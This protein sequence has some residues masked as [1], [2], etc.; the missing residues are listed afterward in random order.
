MREG[1]G[2]FD[3]GGEVT[4]AEDGTFSLT[5]VPREGTLLMLSGAGITPT[6]HRVPAE[7][8]DAD[9]RIVVERSCPFRVSAPTHPDARFQVIDEAGRPLGV[10]QRTGGGRITNTEWRLTSGTT[11]VLRV[12]ERAH[13]VV[14]RDAGG[15]E[16]GRRP[17][18]VRPGIAA[19][20][21]F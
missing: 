14:L 20:V 10:M 12:S 3:I 5:N 16:L 8:A 9:V 4:T 1:Q 21:R 11:E 6:T 19:N 2:V 15:H 17:I 18:V 7:H 13:T